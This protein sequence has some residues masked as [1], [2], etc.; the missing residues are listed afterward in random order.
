MK[1][2]FCLISG[3]MAIFMLSSCTLVVPT[4]KIKEEK[5]AVEEKKEMPE[6]EVEVG[7]NEV[8][9]FWGIWCYASKDGD[10]A[11][12]FAQKLNEKGFD[13]QIFVSSEWTNLNSVT[14]F[15]V[16]AGTYKTEEDA[17][18]VL[19]SVKASGYKDAYVKYSG[20]Y[21]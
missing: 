18:S 16:T 11:D 2:I 9:P 13:A 21:K 7:K 14:H 10:D 12:E 19:E 5:P 17:K 1:R 6:M 20:E 15:V 3:V 4:G 8:E